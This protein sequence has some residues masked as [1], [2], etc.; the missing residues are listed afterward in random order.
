MREQDEKPSDEARNH[1]SGFL[2]KASRLAS[3]RKGGNYKRHW[4]QVKTG[5]R[6]SGR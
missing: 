2:K 5:K 4:S 6:S 3:K 1:S